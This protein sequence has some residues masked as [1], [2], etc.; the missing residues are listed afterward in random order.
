MVCIQARTLLG[1]EY[2]QVH[3]TPKGAP[4]RAQVCPVLENRKPQPP[5]PQPLQFQFIDNPTTPSVWAP[6]SDFCQT[7]GRCSIG[8]CCTYARGPQEG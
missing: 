4:V 7:F 5:T 3:P 1:P 2:T 6:K 8:I